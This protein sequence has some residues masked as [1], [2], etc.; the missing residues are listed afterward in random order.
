MQHVAALKTRPGR[1]GMAAEPPEPR[2]PEPRPPEPRPPPRPPY[3]GPPEPGPPEPG[4]PDA[5]PPGDPGWGDM[6]GR[7]LLG[8]PALVPMHVEALLSAHPV[9]P[10]EP[11][12][13][14]MHLDPHRGWSIFMMLSDKFLSAD[15]AYIAM[16]ASQRTREVLD[17]FIEAGGAA[18]AGDGAPRGLTLYAVVGD[19]GRRGL[20]FPE[21]DEVGYRLWLRD[22]PKPR[23]VKRLWADM[24]SEDEA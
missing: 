4:P 6:R 20:V 19:H 22:P 2:P 15:G 23:A 9:P 18:A 1:T 24:D 21:R 12:R 3:A 8:H 14:T 10:G 16:R 17:A 7:R 13:K 5:G 11:Y